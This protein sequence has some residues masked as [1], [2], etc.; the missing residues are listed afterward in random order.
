MQLASCLDHARHQ[1]FFAR[2]TNKIVF[3]RAYEAQRAI[4]VDTML[5]SRHMYA[6]RRMFDLTYLA[7]AA[8]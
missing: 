5:G 7:D 3:F 8:K 1:V 4:H 2:T 6:R